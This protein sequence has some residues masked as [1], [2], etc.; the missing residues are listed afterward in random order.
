MITMNA[1]LEVLK[2][3]N[4]LE[5]SRTPKN[6]RKYGDSLRISYSYFHVYY[7]AETQPQKFDK[8]VVFRGFSANIS[9]IFLLKVRVGEFVESVL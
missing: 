8:F 4:I 9:Q 3:S 1:Y 5:I 7:A 6:E 2:L